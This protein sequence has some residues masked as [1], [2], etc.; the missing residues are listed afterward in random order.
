MSHNETELN[1]AV[2]KRFILD[3]CAV[4]YYNPTYSHNRYFFVGTNFVNLVKNTQRFNADH[5]ID[6]PLQIELELRASALT[7]NQNATFASGQYVMGFSQ[8]TTIARVNIFLSSVSTSLSLVDAYTNSSYAGIASSGIV[9]YCSGTSTLGYRQPGDPIFNAPGEV[10]TRVYDPRV[11]HTSYF[12]NM[13][14]TSSTLFR[15]SRR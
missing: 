10:R 5:D 3:R 11:S 7:P 15:P 2:Q 1:R 14:T 4:V 12:T 6:L 13:T 9:L 8:T